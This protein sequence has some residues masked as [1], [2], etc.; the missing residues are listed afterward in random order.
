MYLLGFYFFFVSIGQAVEAGQ[1][2]KI[3]RFRPIVFDKAT[4][5]HPLTIKIIPML[6]C[7]PECEDLHIEPK[8]R[9]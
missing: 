8:I 6:K 5:L 2:S 7:S 4:Q 9:V 3:N 1:H